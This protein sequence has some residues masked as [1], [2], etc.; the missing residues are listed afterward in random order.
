[1]LIIALVGMMSVLPHVG[2]EQGILG[3]IH[4]QIVM[5]VLI[6]VFI[7]AVIMAVVVDTVVVLLVAVVTLLVEAEVEMVEVVGLQSLQGQN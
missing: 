4:P 2:P 3:T 6:A 1:M 7:P 5:I